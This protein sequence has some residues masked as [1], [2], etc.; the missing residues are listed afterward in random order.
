MAVQDQ[1]LVT[2]A[3]RVTILKQ[4][5]SNKCR[6][7]NKRDETVIPSVNVHSW[8]WLSIRHNM[9]RSSLWLTCSKYGFEPAKHWYEHGAEKVVENQDTKNL[10]DYNI[11]TGRVICYDTISAYNSYTISTT[12]ISM[13]NSNLIIWFL[14]F[15][16]LSILS[17][18]HYWE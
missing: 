15:L 12:I 13:T 8:L 11:K 5:S 10:W 1:T 18:A 17:S 4:Q 9:I 16:H 6:M 7:C 3:Y 2:K 14:D